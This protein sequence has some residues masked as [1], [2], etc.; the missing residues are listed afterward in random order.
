MLFNYSI[1]ALTLLT[2]LVIVA[3]LIVSV[4]YGIRDDDDV[5]YTASQYSVVRHSS[6]EAISTRQPI[7]RHHAVYVIACP[8][9]FQRYY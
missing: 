8:G 7:C 3:L 6:A 5:E 1:S 2:Q 4:G 9:Y